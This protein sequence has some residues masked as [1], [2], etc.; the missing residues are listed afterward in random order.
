MKLKA[1]GLFIGLFSFLCCGISKEARQV[2]LYQDHLAAML[3]KNE[4][5]VSEQIVKTWRFE[6]LHLWQADDP[7]AEAVIKNNYRTHGFSKAEAQSIFAPK[8]KY[9]VEIYLK[10]LSTE[11]VR[12]GKIDGMGFSLPESQQRQT[13]R[14]YAY[15]RVVFKDG[16]LIHV[17]TW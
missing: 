2:K 1:L 14:Q 16:K 9:K 3:E 15:I 17:L 11:E 8:G 12:T 5:E 13:S 6:L 4:E 7:S 10:T